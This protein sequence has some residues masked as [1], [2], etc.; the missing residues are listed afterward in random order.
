MRNQVTTFNIVQF[1][2]VVSMVLVLTNGVSA[3]AG[4]V[5]DNAS[6]FN[7]RMSR[8]CGKE[9]LVKNSITDK[10]LEPLL[11]GKDLDVTIAE[12]RLEL[13]VLQNSAAPEYTVQMKRSVK[14]AKEALLAFERTPYSILCSHEISSQLSMVLYCTAL[15]GITRDEKI[16]VLW[17]RISNHTRAL[18]MASDALLTQ[19]YSQN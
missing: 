18:S 14:G 12:T 13:E 6:R 2:S 9:K 3:Q 19:F 16:Q 4:S 5:S 1:V 15:F 8:P 17:G 11:C 7:E 10:V